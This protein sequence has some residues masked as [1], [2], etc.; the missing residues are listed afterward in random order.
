MQIVT[1]GCLVA[2]INA[3]LWTGEQMRSERWICLL[4]YSKVLPPVF[5]RQQRMKATFCL[6]LKRISLTQLMLIMVSGS[7]RTVMEFNQH[8]AINY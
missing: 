7:R 2:D 5:R 4:L 8:K 3:E 1:R 6:A